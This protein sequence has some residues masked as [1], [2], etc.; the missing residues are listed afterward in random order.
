MK[1]VI[2]ASGSG[3]LAQAVIAAKENGELAIEIS[4]LISDRQCAALQRASDAGIAANLIDFKAYPNREL[5]S[6][7]LATSLAATD[8]DLVVSLG[9]MRILPPFIV[10]EFKIINTHPALLPLFPGAHAVRDAIAAGASETGTTVH[11]V[12][13][14]VDTGQVIDQRRIAI[15]PGEDE[16]SLHERIKIEERRLIVETLARMAKQFN[17]TGA[18]K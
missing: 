4:S 16:S 6:K 8:A 10:E 13:A 9:F 17:E 1:I 15:T 3:S 14:G 5:W 7:A 18:I 2:L 11:W 12:D